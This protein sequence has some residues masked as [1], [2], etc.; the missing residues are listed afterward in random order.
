ME[1]DTAERL[2]A[3]LHEIDFPSL[4]NLSLPVK[5]RDSLVKLAK[6]KLKLVKRQLREEMDVIKKRWDGRNSYEAAQERLH[7]APYKVLDDLI[8]KLEVAITE[9][10]IKGSEAKPVTF[11]TQLVGNFDTGEWHVL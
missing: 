6:Q 2:L 9:L 8:A 5:D 7:L 11:G 4:Y 10:E 1:T 3:Q